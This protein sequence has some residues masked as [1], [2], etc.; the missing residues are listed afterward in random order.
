[1]A[2]NA[3]CPEFRNHFGNAMLVGIV[4]GNGSKEPER[5]SPYL[6]VLVDEMLELTGST[7]LDAYCKAPFELKLEIL[8]YVLD[9]P[10]IGKVFGVAGSGAHMGCTW[11]DLESNGIMCI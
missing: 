8:L 1:M 11:C 10:G 7:I 9:Y 2:N 4:P 5:I 6:E 3:N